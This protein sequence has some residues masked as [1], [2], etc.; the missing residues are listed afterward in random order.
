MG[1]F[2]QCCRSIPY[3]SLVAAVLVVGG[4]IVF[5]LQLYEAVN[6]IATD[7]LETHFQVNV[8][9]LDAIRLAFICVAAIMAFFSLVML[10]TAFIAT[11]R[12]REHCC[13]GGCTN[14]CGRF[15]TVIFIFLTWLFHIVWLIVS[16]ALAVALFI[17]LMLVGACAG[18][19]A[20]QNEAEKL[21]LD[22]ANY[23][24]DLSNLDSTGNSTLKVC[25]KGNVEAVCDQVERVGGGLIGA[26]VGSLVMVVGLFHFVAALSANFVHLKKEIERYDRYMPDGENM[27]M[28]PMKA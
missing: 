6:I 23:G 9:W 28:V 5:G 14:A 19:I 26:L 1:G 15:T 22:L 2:Y 10:I 24:I 11:G 21:C 25:G 16:C 3:A 18:L 20:L 17:Q 12:S 8:P 7:I 4:V 13:K 27:A